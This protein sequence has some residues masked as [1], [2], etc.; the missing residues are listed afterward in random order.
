MPITTSDSDDDAIFR[1]HQRYKALDHKDTAI[2]PKFTMGDMGRLTSV[3]LY[4]E[5]K[6]Y[7]EYRATCG[8]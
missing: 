2:L 4:L 6:D 1:L 8:Y 5:E 3:L 7:I